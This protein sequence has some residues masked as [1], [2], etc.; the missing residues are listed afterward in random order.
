[1]GKITAALCAL[2]LLCA[3][4]ASLFTPEQ[5]E[6]LRAVVQDQY[7]TGQITEAQRDAAIEALDT[8]AAGTDWMANL[9]FLGASLL[10]ALLGI[11]I[12][13]RQVNRRTAAAK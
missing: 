12:S 8:D 7:A 6:N 13:V 4:C 5:R 3:G 11:P 2:A 9:G 1:M 10:G